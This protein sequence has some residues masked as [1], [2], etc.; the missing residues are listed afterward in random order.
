MVLLLVFLFLLSPGV[1]FSENLEA[2]FLVVT[3]PVADIRKEPLDKKPGYNHDN[4]QN[5]QAIFNEALLYGFSKGDWY[6]VEAVE[7]KE[8]THNNKWQGYPGYI[9]KEK[10][11]FIGNLPEYDLVVNVGATNILNEPSQ[12][13][14]ALFRVSLGTKFK[15]TGVREDF[16][17][18]EIGEAGHGWVNEKD[19]RRIDDSRD[20]NNIR[21][22][23]VKTARLFL[24]S[25]YLWG[26]RGLAGGIDC[27]G[28]TNLVYRASGIDIPRDAQEQ[29]MLAERISDTE[30]RPADLIFLSGKKGF[31][32]IVHVMFFTGGEDFIE[33]PG[34]GKTVCAGNFKTKFGM[35]LES[36][37]KKNFIADGKKIYFG[38]VKALDRKEK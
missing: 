38:R 31:D 19:V 2:R 32:S 28:L 1:V 29:W 27:S 11:R 34:T 10:V 21:E 33:A 6:Y 18:V 17:E 4:L 36:L 7:Q 30:L 37:K 5:T 35:N 15:M 16:Y 24:G 3:S 20:E 26:G 12:S 23:L 8:F 9:R 14:Q 22:G 25:P 13:A